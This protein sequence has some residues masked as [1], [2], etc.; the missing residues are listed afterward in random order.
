MGSPFQFGKTAQGSAFTNRIKEI[1]RLSNN[2][3]NNIHT[4]LISPRRW[5]KTSLIKKVA[6]KYINKQQYKFCFLDLFNVRSENDFYEYL[7]IE[8]IKS[9]STKVEEWFK[10]TQT[11]LS[12]ISPKLSMSA[13]TDTDFSIQFDIQENDRSIFEILNLTEKISKRKKIRIIL[14]IDEFQNIETFKDPLGFQQKL[15]AQWQHHQHVTYCLYGSKRHMLMNLFESQSL[16]FYKFGDVMYL[17]KIAKKDF[18]K[19]IVKNFE[20]TNKSIPVAVA[21]KLVDLMEC[22]PHYVQHLAHITWK[23]SKKKVTEAILDQSKDEL[24]YVNSLLFEKIFELLS[25][26]QIKLLK[27]L[28]DGINEH[29][30]SKDVINKYGLGTSANVAKMLKALENKEIID[31][32][33]TELSF[34]DPPFR[35]WL[36]EIFKKYK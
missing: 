1:Q 4:I 23:N 19:F 21:E 28:T 22:H 35:L 24:L 17:E 25:N 5:G 6:Q 11:F 14:C 29:F 34:V 33:G 2:I 31:R 27:A 12:K 26:G 8:V 3:E 13:G 15:R 32:F 36:T 7:A 10:I 20:Q 9:T 18:T 30:S 16:P